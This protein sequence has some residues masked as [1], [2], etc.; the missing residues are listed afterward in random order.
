MTEKPKRKRWHDNRQRLQPNVLRSTVLR[1]RVSAAEMEVLQ[2]KAGRMAM[3]V[4]S[5][6]RYAGVTRKLRPCPV[7]TVNRDVYRELCRIGN[8]INQLTKEVHQGHTSISSAELEGLKALLRKTKNLL[9][10]S[11]DSE[12]D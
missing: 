6:L 4:S 2:E 5:W 12:A 1:V 11:D 8:N 7:P 3:P 10:G 9:V